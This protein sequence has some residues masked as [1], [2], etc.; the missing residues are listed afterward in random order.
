MTG[1]AHKA[2]TFLMTCLS[3]GALIVCAAASAHAAP[4]SSVAA[5]QRQIARQIY[6]QLPQPGY[7]RVLYCDGPS[8]IGFDI[9]SNGHTS[10]V[11][12]VR[13]ADPSIDGV[14]V[15]QINNMIF[16]KPPVPP[17]SRSFPTAYSYG[18]RAYNVPTL[19]L[20]SNCRR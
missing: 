2:R 16:P 6:D 13:A 20:S 9:L 10:H 11:R 8:V 7:S 1:T 19:A 5:Y 14:L 4:P 3:A 18:L 15:A 17:G 12:L